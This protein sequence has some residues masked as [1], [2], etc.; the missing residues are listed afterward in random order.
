M[1]LAGTDVEMQS[2]WFRVRSRVAQGVMP[3]D[4]VVVPVI[5]TRM[6]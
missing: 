1:P 4:S 5:M 2:T 3:V 6:G